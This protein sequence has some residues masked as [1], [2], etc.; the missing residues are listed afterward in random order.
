MLVGTGLGYCQMASGDQGW[1]WEM[2]ACSG[3]RVY[4]RRGW[5]RRV[6]SEGWS[7]SIDVRMRAEGG[8]G[9]WRV[10]SGGLWVQVEAWNG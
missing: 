7:L 5:G 8:G 3:C 9:G 2:A 4:I 1:E 10:H 6:G